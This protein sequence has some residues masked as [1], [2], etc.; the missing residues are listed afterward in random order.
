M[1]RGGFLYMSRVG[2]VLFP[3]RQ[4][5]T[6][7]P[8]KLLLLWLKIIFRCTQTCF[9]SKLCPHLLHLL[10]HDV[11][12]LQPTSGCTWTTESRLQ[13]FLAS[14][15]SFHLHY[16]HLRPPLPSHA[17]HVQPF[18]CPSPLQPQK[19]SFELQECFRAAPL[20]AK[21]SCTHSKTHDVLSC[22]DDPWLLLQSRV[23]KQIIVPSRNF[24]F[25]DGFGRSHCFH[26][27]D[28]RAKDSLLILH[29]PEE[30]KSLLPDV[31]KTFWGTP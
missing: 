26:P 14:C 16:E 6:N 24:S 23:N 1:L 4:E 30:M 28:K 7:T 15:I 8:S 13:E 10:L 25:T 21:H 18:V 5:K 12:V 19:F 20:H 29:V 17:P 2:V 3:C 31:I 9:T 11:S 27:S 22:G